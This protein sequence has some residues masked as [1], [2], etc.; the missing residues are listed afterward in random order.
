MVIADLAGNGITV[1]GNDTVAPVLASATVNGATLV[2][3]Y[4]DVNNLD[5][6]NIAAPGAFAVLTGGSPNAVTAV[7]V[8][9]AARTVTL[10]LTTPATHLQAVTVAYADPTAGDDANATQDIAGNDAATFAAT[11]VTNNTPDTTAP[12]FASA[13]VSGNTLVMSYTD[14]SNL[15]AT[16]VPV[17]GAFTVVSGGGSNAVTSVSVN[18]AA[19]TVTLSLAATI[20]SADI[21][22]VAYADPT[23][24]DDANAIQDASGNDAATLATTGVSNTTPAPPAPPGNTPGTG[25]GITIVGGAAGAQP[26]QGDTLAAVTQSMV[27]PQGVGAPLGY[28]WLREGAAIAGA[29]NA[30]YVLD[31][32]D[33][34]TRVSVAVSYTDGGGNAERVVAPATGLVAGNDGAPNS[35]ESLA[36]A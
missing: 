30:T 27:D 8:N 19:R 9:A 21:V 32:A 26:Q 11:T 12:V 3:A 7:A 28:Q 35:L 36:P 15:D 31:A 25:A 4:T 18:A 10:T 14:A 6:V 1:T 13:T 17:A 23:A 2:L 20:S 33:V 16:N 34:N 22:T 24:G 29:T 5:A